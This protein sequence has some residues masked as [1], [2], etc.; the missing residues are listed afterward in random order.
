MFQSSVRQG[1]RWSPVSAYGVQWLPTRT[2]PLIHWLSVCLVLWAISLPLM[3][4]RLSRTAPSVRVFSPAVA[5]CYL[6]F[7]CLFV[8]LF[9]S[10]YSV[11]SV[12]KQKHLLFQLYDHICKREKNRLLSCL[13]VSS[14]SS[15]LPTL[16]FSVLFVK[17][18]PFVPVLHVVNKDNGSCS[19][20]MVLRSISMLVQDIQNVKQNA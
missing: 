16:Y 2:T 7:V 12:I 13:F 8:C 15:F 9:V 17:Y 6:G 3:L 19:Q 11:L 20:Q 14:P 1:S 18:L 10:S 4:L 5:G